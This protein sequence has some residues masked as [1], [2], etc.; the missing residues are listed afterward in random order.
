MRNLTT[1]VES[2]FLDERGIWPNTLDAFGVETTDTE[3]RLPYPNGTKTRFFRADGT[4]SFAFEKGMTPMLFG[5]MDATEISFIVEGETDTMRLWQELDG[6]FAVFGISGTS[7]WRDEYSS[8]LKGAETVYVILDNDTNPTAYG[9]VDTAWLNIRK[10]LG[11]RAV[12]LRLP[13]EVKD[14]CEFFDQY[15]VE[16]LRLMAE[17]A[18]TQSLHY[19]PL[20]LTKPAPPTDWLVNDLVAS[21][22]VVL[23]T[24]EPN[25]GKSF[26]TMALAAH[27]AN[28]GGS[29]LGQTVC[30]TGRVLYIDEE[31]PADVVQQRMA[32]LGLKPDDAANIRYLHQQGVRLDKHPEKV[33][34]EALAWSPELIVVDSMARIHTGDENNAGAIAT[35]FN[36]GIN[37]LSRQTGATV[38]VL[39]HVTK[40]ESGSAFF[41]VRGSGDIT[42]SI[43]TGL[44]VRRAGATNLHVVHF[45]SRRRSAGDVKQI[46]ILDKPDGSIEI[47][48]QKALVF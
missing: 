12:R 27:V 31:N 6:E 41:R 39:H 29:W 21:G 47:A 42:A 28:S 8:V 43:D 10:A 23:L 16:T 19:Q 32:K 3:A 46:Q 22:D 5:T 20:D 45:K 33:L 30:K 26:L 2:W 44:D 13:S 37:P 17:V 25:V 24:G 15:D 48:T 35:L 11:P 34:D 4:R 18:P 14:V 1:E 36:D 40:T 9:Q 7:G 38:F